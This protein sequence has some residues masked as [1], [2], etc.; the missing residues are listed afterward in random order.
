MFGAGVDR[1]TPYS[2]EIP[3]NFENHHQYRESAP[4]FK[5]QTAAPFG[6]AVAWGI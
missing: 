3:N 6:A 5:T 1:S 2:Q 4:V